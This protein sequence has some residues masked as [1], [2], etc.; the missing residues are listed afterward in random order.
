MRYVSNLIRHEGPGTILSAL[1]DKGW[2]DVLMAGNQI[3]GKGFG[4]FHIIADL[5]EEG[6][7]K[8]DEIITLIFQVYKNFV[9]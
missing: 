8:V 6:I 5:T 3:G 9:E 4:F 2:C 7:D 1:K